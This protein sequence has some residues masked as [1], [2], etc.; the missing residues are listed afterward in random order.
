MRPFHVEEIRDFVK[1]MKGNA[2]GI[3]GVRLSH[4]KKIPF[5]EITEW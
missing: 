4:L 5:D 2:D 1:A 3:E